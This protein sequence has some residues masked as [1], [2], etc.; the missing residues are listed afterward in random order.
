MAL[1]RKIPGELDITLSTS[2]TEEQTIWDNTDGVVS[3]FSRQP[4]EIQAAGE[5]IYDGTTLHDLT[6]KG[7]DEDAD[8]AVKLL[9][10]GTEDLQVDFR[11]RRQDEN[12]FIALKIDFVA[13][14]IELVE[15]IAGVETSLD[16]ASHNFK[17][18]GRTRYNFGIMMIGTSLHGVVNGFEIVQASTS[19]FRAEPGLSISF[20][21]FNAS[22]PPAMYTISATETE[23]FPD[24]SPVYFSGTATVPDT[25]DILLAFRQSIKQ[26]I[27][28]P[29]VR[30]WDSY[31]KA[32][33]FYEQRH[34]GYTDSVW[35][36]LGYP[37][38]KPSAEE[39]FGN[40]P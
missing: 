2:P 22:D 12:N 30:D 4:L 21:T 34:V 23:A 38:Q 40:L 5:L 25:C 24:P 3:D 15:T 29:T 8:Y 1:P 18:E 35:E 17:F 27:E 6:G 19:S 32:V 7:D 11:V 16:Q 13:N 36:E 33:K 28:N 26:Q 9:F 20:S 14:T 31:V 39:W 10:M 37:I